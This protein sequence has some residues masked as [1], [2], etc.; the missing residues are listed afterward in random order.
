M[1]GYEPEEGYVDIE[2]VATP[3]EDASSVLVSWVIMLAIIIIISL[4]S[5]RS[6]RMFIF[7]IPHIHGGFSSYNFHSSGGFGG[8]KGGGG[9]F[10]GGGAGRGF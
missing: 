10:G 2:N 1:Y 5:R 4:I 7:G 8:F 9:S 6:G 3:T